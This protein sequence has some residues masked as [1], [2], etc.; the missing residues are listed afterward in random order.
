MRCWV[1]LGL[2]LGAGHASS[3]KDAFD[4]SLEELLDLRI[5]I[6][7]RNEES[8][9]DAPS[10][11]TVFTRGELDAL[12]ITTL[13]ELA[14]FVP[15]LRAYRW[16]SNSPQ[17]QTFAPRGVPVP[18]SNGVLFLFNGH[19]LN[20]ELTGGP[21]FTRYISLASIARVEIIRGPGSALY[22][23]NAFQAVI[24]L[25]SDDGADLVAL[26]AGTAQGRRATLRHRG[27]LGEAS[28]ALT[29]EGYRDA[30]VRYDDAFDPANPARPTT[31]RDPW[32]GEE[33]IANAHWHDW[34]LLWRE[35]RRHSEDFYLLGGLMPDGGY[36]K[37][38][39]RLLSLNH[40][41]LS[42][43]EGWHGSMHFDH[44]RGYNATLGQL[45]PQVPPFSQ[46][47]WQAGTRVRFKRYEWATDWR[48]DVDANTRLNLGLTAVYVPESYAFIQ[49][50]YTNEFPPRFLGLVQTLSGERARFL[51]PVTRRAYGVYVQYQRQLSQAWQTSLGLRHDRYSDVGGA[52]TPRAALIYT[53]P[54]GDRV[55]LLYGR[56]FRA[57]THTELYN[58]NNPVLLGN[59]DLDPP[60]I[61]TL[62]LGYVHAGPRAN[63]SATLFDNHIE[64]FIARRQLPSGQAESQNI[65]SLRTR[66]VEFEGQWQLADA[67]R[68]RLA[69]TQ[70]LH[71]RQ[72]FDAQA[73]AIDVPGQSPKRWG[74]FALTYDRA[75]W[76]LT[77]YGLY[78]G[79]TP[80]LVGQS[81][82]WLGGLAGRYQIAPRLALTLRVSN[83]ADLDYDTIGD[84][85]GLGRGIN[86]QVV[87]NVPNRG[88]FAWAGLEWRY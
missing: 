12:G 18:S 70:I 24:N 48:Y 80:L 63:Y 73:V 11:V 35:S 81:A 1:A 78:S 25:I 82:Y 71:N 10:T 53:A 5:T 47:P 6:A 45:A 61:G 22:G 30:G 13:D 44:L 19:R 84:D 54:W 75:P 3:A 49:S 50:N 55:K 62:E 8:P 29:F 7:S 41:A 87:R 36:V 42:L 57:P 88:R 27:H 21:S 14:A 26:E 83:L 17:G 67:W 2:L 69:Y 39:D 20:A 52:T 77:V 40:G 38:T 64:D 56:A 72:S 28:F 43:G 16:I 76:Q 51:E 15:G 65:G 66:G 4:M 46:A 86:R 79:R 9:A 34:Q 33:L 58:I 68:G 32:S 23:S 85:T 31:T 59:P 60:R 74:S 37:T